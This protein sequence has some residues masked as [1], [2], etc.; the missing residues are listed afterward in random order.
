[1]EATE[2]STVKRKSIGRLL[3]RIPQNIATTVEHFFY[4]LGIQIARQPIIWILGCSI[5]VLLCIGG[6]YRFRQEK[7]PLKL[8]VPPDSDFVKDTE[9]LMERFGEGQRVETVIMTADDVLQPH[10]LFEMNEIIKRIM[11]MET[12]SQPKLYWTDV[13]FKI[14]IIS[15]YTNREKRDIEDDDFFEEEPAARSDKINFDPSVH[16]PTKVYCDILNN[17]PT[18]CLILS[19]LDLWEYNS[20]LI[21]NQTKAD[22][23]KKINSAEI[24]P[25]LGHPMNFTELLGGTVTD[26]TGKIVSAKAL[27]T[28]WMLHVDFKQ[29]NMNDAGNDVGTSDWATLDV[30][31][32]E[33]AFINQLHSS[34]EYLKKNNLITNQ[35]LEIWYEAGRSFGDISASTM[36]QDI[37]KVII[38]IVLMTLYVQII[39][40]R[41]NWLEWR[42]CLTSAGLLCVGGA[43]VVAVGLCS[44]FGVPYGPVHSSLPFMLMGL[45]VDDIFVMM[46]SWE[47]VLSHESNRVKSV[48]E[49]IGIMLSHAGAAISITSLTDVVAFIIGASTILP[50]LESF[51]IYAAVGVLVTFLLQVTFFVAVFTLDVRRIESKRNGVIPCIVHKNHQT[52]QVDPSKTISWRI[53]NWLYSKIVLTL[54]GKIFIILI[55]A[56]VTVIGGIGAYNLEQWFD[57]NWFLPKESYLSN[58]ININDKQF[59]NRGNPAAIYIADIDYLNEFPKLITVTE[60]LINMTTIIN[61]VESWPHDFADFVTL[62]YE[63]DVT[64]NN[65]V[66]VDDFNF[67]LSKFLFSRSGG[68]YQKNFRFNG[69]LTCGKNTPKIMLSSISLSF[70]KFSGPDEWIPAMDAVKLVVKETNFSNYATIWSKIFAAWVTDKVIAR[71]VTRN[72]IL[73][74]ICVMGTTAV[75]IAEPQTC[76]WILLCV[77][78]TLV[79]ICGFMYYW[80]L[81]VDIVSCIGLELAVGLSV[82]YA[83]HVAHAF[84]NSKSPNDA[85]GDENNRTVRALIAVRHIGAAVLYGAGSTLLA[86]SLLAFSE[87][88]VFRTFFKIFFLVI[89]FGV[90]HGL[91]LLPVILSSIGPQSLQVGRTK[92]DKNT[93]NND[94]NN[95]IVLDSDIDSK[96]LSAQIPLNFIQN[97]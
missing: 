62:H 20:D 5:V 77:S 17:L 24:S 50:S 32:W 74:L 96:D 16:A 82:D 64:N 25:T 68:R 31:N 26:D 75:L 36:F 76:I 23:I 79:D 45:G 37:K 43:F 6:L 85:G 40:S 10:V 30:L 94:K 73:A 48:E 35:S 97:D 71:E 58:Y 88:Y 2:E 59:P 27:K 49:R 83:A 93:S 51:C 66:T 46:A 86:Q 29:I 8:W 80:G 13:C 12:D 19:I 22:I 67:Y 56:S 61:S 3:K 34:S 84:L 54:S 95:A 39:L 38:G 78:L 53:F 47:E 9:W 69:T 63:I 91:F 42:F 44:L 15:G 72:I 89:S 92:I 7:N 41:F 90:W 4:S 87:A 55:T 60:R 14:P 21:F 33:S 1:M 28:H 52:P 57:P 81:S 65:T 70:K 11:S 18:G